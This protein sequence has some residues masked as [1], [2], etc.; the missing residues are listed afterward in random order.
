MMMWESCPLAH[1]R[2]LAGKIYYPELL[3]EKVFPAR[4]QKLARLFSLL[5]GMATWLIRSFI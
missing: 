1:L 3:L 5:P 2:I 4:L